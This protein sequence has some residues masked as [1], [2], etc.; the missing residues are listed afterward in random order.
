MMVSDG[1][2][3]F[4]PEVGTVEPTSCL[5][6]LMDLMIS[7]VVVILPRRAHLAG[8]VWLHKCIHI[9]MATVRYS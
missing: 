1:F 7:E 8:C 9:G 3:T 2:A 5:A 4:Q 6:W